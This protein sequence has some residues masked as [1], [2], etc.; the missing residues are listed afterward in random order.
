MN[1]KFW[2]VTAVDYS[3]NCD[4]K[5]HVLDVCKTCEE[6]EAYVRAD[7][8]SYA[9]SYTGEDVEVDFDKMCA[10]VNVLNGCEWN[11]EERDVD[12]PS[13]LEDEKASHDTAGNKF[14]QEE[15]QFM[16]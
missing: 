3:E 9:D 1:L 7:I 6:A 10:S 4:G 5:A 14:H 12:V 8:E 11:I 2:I 16:K 13:G 15:F